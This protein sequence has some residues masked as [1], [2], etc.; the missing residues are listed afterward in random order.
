MVI[1]V[2]SDNYSDFNEV[3]EFYLLKVAGIIERLL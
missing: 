2:D 1:D 3:D